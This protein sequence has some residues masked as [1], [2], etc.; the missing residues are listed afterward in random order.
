MAFLLSS[1]SGFTTGQTVT[2]DGGM[3]LLHSLID[4]APDVFFHPSM[5]DEHTHFTKYEA[6]TK[7]AHVGVGGEPTIE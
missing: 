3:K 7:D 6:K 4:V 5:R 1:K 2:I